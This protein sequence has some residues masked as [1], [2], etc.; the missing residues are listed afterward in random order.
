MGYGKNTG[1]PRRPAWAPI[2]SFIWPGLGQ[3]Y[4]RRRRAGIALA[5]VM[6][7]ALLAALA[8]AAGGAGAVLAAIVDPL[9]ATAIVSCVVVLGVVRVVAILDAARSST[10][11]SPSRRGQ[12]SI[13]VLA[14]G[15]ALVVVASH[16]A[17]ALVAYDMHVAT[18]RIFTGD[19]PQPTLT[20]GTGQASESPGPSSSGDLGSAPPAVP[21]TG[22]RLNVLLIGADSGTGYNHA[23]TDSMI[24][25]SVDKATGKVAMVSMPR[26]LARFK[27]YNGRMWGEKLNALVTL[28]NMRPSE[29]PL[30]GLGTL[31]KQI[32]F[33]LGIQ[34][35]Y[36][37]YIDLGGFKKLIDAVGG[38]DVTVD[39]DIAD[40]TYDMGGGQI[41]FY[42]TAGRHHL[43]GRL[44]TA[45]VRSRHGPDGS[46][47]TR[48]R[49][50]QQVLIGLREKLSDPAM[51]T[52]LP[53]ILEAAPGVISTN[54]PPSK[55]GEL[56]A[57]SQQ[58]GDPA[59]SRVVLGPPYAI[60]PPTSSTGG[61]YILTL[62]E[63][64][65]RALSVL[66]FGADSAFF[67]A[68]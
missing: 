41:G 32:G 46:D 2:L 60:H 39:S 34:I 19:T 22:S 43:D 24:V 33:M 62:V 13:K 48:A 63:E 25:V 21:P 29:F 37:A 51:L 30:G 38:I 36:Y 23:L 18:A 12:R 59:I 17:L 47:F 1:E 50:Q 49:R 55:V 58:L 68:N 8:L 65:V 61:S 66:L 44:A 20:P 6:A 31:T 14:V 3:L 16:V 40:S 53:A 11:P 42:L 15:L 26:D 64:K 52:R 35:N 57:L 5:A 45:F 27:L 56:L 7:V 54:Y 9:A 4:L 28:A 67:G 10:R